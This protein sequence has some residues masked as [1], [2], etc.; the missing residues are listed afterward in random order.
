MYENLSSL[1]VNNYSAVT[2]P[3]VWIGQMDDYG[4]S[5]VL[6]RCVSNDASA[7]LQWFSIDNTE[8]TPPV[9]VPSTTDGDLE[10]DLYTLSATNLI[11]YY[12]TATNSF[13][14]ARTVPFRAYS[15]PCMF[16]L[17]KD[18]QSLYVISYL[19]L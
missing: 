19:S 8:G 6:V 9:P 17:S 1:F 7:E 10:V 14:A 15:P 12:C 18:I 5:S 3:E 13:G 16:C 2:I 4:D 11:D